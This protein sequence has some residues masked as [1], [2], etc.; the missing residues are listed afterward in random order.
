[1]LSLHKA[2]VSVVAHSPK[3]NPARPWAWRVFTAIEV[4]VGGA[5]VAE[6]GIVEEGE[7]WYVVRPNG[8]RWRR[9]YTSEDGARKA[10]ASSIQPPA[11]KVAPA[12]AVELRTRTLAQ[13]HCRSGRKA[14]EA[15]QKQLI[16]AGKLRRPQRA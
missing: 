14:H 3:Q 13:G 2:T 15:C 8:T 5:P 12:I 7:R 6:L 11:P 1:M 16:A 4:E 9:G 10:I